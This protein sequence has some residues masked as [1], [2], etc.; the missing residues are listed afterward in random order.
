[1][2]ILDAFNEKCGELFKSRFA[3]VNRNL[4]KLNKVET[5]LV[6]NYTKNNLSKA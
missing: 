5:Y 6:Q 4:L 3:Q 2:F 1:V